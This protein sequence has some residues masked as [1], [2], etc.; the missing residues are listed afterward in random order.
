MKGRKKAVALAWKRS[1]RAPVIVARG[2]GYLAA[3]MLAQAEF[4]RIPIVRDDPL[5]ETLAAFPPGVYVPEETW[6]ALAAVFAT[7]DEIAQDKNVT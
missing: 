6:R 4:R 2:S 3:S 1:L 5:A 7:L